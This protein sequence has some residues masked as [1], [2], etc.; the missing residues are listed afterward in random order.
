MYDA[1]YAREQK[2]K[3][4]AAFESLGSTSYGKVLDVGCG[5]GLLFEYLADKAETTIGLDISRKTLNKAKERMQPFPNVHLIL[6]DADYIPLQGKVFSH[7]FAMTLI[8]NVPKP[9]DTLNEIT[10]VARNDAKIVLTALRKVFTMENFKKLVRDTDLKIVAL[11][12]DGLQCYVAV[13]TQ[14]LH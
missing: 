6:A 14:V 13:C 1:R 7:V 4:E 3:Y 11:H 5:T 2:A 10:R 8:Q 12:E 9:I